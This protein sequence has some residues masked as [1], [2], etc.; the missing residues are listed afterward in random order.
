MEGKI[1]NIIA[2]QLCSKITEVVNEAKLIED[3]GADELDRIELTMAL[4]EEFG[5]CISDDEADKWAT[6]GDVVSYIE[7]NKKG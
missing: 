7:N 1:K 6:V 2:D 5:I 3:L 4:E